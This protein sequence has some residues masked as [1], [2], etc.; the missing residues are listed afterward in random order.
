VRL[1]SGSL[2]QQHLYHGHAQANKTR[3]ILTGLNVGRQLA[4]RRL[5][6]F[7]GVEAPRGYVF[8]AAAMVGLAVLLVAGAVLHA[9]WVAVAG[10]VLLM[11]AAV[12]RERLAWRNQSWLALAVVASVVA[13]SYLAQLIIG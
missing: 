12:L 13:A 7:T 2:G 3:S 1:R 11:L 5:V 4:S 6:A 8:V 9:A 10:F